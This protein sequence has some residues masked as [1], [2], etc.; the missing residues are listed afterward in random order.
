MTGMRG[1]S[2]IPLGQEHQDGC[3]LALDLLSKGRCDYDK[4]TQ[5]AG[6]T[7]QG[8]VEAGRGKEEILIKS[9]HKEC[10]P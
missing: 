7:R 9:P 4:E 8:N 2:L 3:M 5:Q 1:S 6:S 10:T